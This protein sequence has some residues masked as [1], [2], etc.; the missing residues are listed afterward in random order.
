MAVSS[1]KEEDLEKVGD[2]LKGDKE[3]FAFLFRKYRERIYQVVYGYVRNKEDALDIT[4]DTFLKAYR[5]LASY[6]RK[7]GFYTWLCQIAINKAIDHIRRRKRKPFSLE[8]YMLT[9]KVT[10]SAA[11][12]QADP[13]RAAQERE[14]VANFLG[15]LEKLSENHRT[16]FYLN[17]V[18]GLTYRE[19]AETVDCSIGTV[20]SR[21][22]YARKKLQSLM[23]AYRRTSVEE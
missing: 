13:V 5:S 21:L 18:L 9:G 16:A 7:A 8:E 2:C 1:S 10:E 14:L 3:A 23:K 12:G 22:H 4:Q 15:A 11:A 6:N 19:I 20:M 17:A